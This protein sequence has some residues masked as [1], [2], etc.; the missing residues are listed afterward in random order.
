MAKRRL[1]L[2]ECNLDYALFQKLRERNLIPREIEVFRKHG[3]IG[4]AL[5]KIPH[6]LNVFPRLYVAIDLDAYTSIELVKRLAQQIDGRAVP[7]GKHLHV[8]D[9]E[10]SRILIE[11]RGGR[12]AVEKLL[13]IIPLGIPQSQRLRELGVKRHMVEDYYVEAILQVE[14][15]RARRALATKEYVSSKRVLEELLEQLGV[16]REEADEFLNAV[17]DRC[18]LSAVASNI[19]EKFLSE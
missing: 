11:L 10:E 14:G 19:I 2:V 9:I 3:G 13:H 17:L 15:D 8:A 6:I 5:E 12:E 4:F 1:L 16:S 18:D 7:G